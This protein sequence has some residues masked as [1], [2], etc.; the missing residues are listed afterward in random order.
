[1]SPPQQSIARH[2]IDLFSRAV[3]L[4]QAG[5]LDE[6]EPLYT[7]ILSADKRNFDALRLLGLLEAQR[8]NLARAH[9]LLRKALKLRPRSA[10]VFIN[11]GNVLKLQD[12]L[13]EALVAYT[14]ALKIEPNSILAL[15]LR[16]I[17]LSALQRF[18]EARATFDAAL[19]IKHDYAE[20][21]YNRGILLL[22]AHRGAEAL[23]DLDKARALR[24]NDPQILLARGN[25]LLLLSRIDEA[26]ESFERALTIQPG[27]VEAMV[28]LGTALRM[29][30]RLSEALAIYDQALAARADYAEVFFNR[31]LVL[32]D[33]KRFDEALTCL[34]R[35]L[36]LRPDFA[37]A[38]LNRGHTLC[39]LKRFE[40]AAAA[41][42]RA[43]SLKPDLVEVW[44]GRG[45]LF[46]QLKQW[47][48]ALAAYERAAA[49]KPDLAEAYCGSGV[50]FTKTAQYEQA[51]AAY[52]SAIQL[53]P[54]LSEAWLGRG[55]VFYE[56]KRLNEALAAYDKALALNPDLPAAW[57]GRG[58]VFYELKRYT[59][60]IAAYDKAIALQP[61]L[62]EA[63]VRLYAKLMI[64][65][66]A[67]W[68]AEFSRFLSAT[69]NG[70]STHPFQLLSIP[71]SAAD[72][73]ACAKCF[74]A[75]RPLPS[76]APLWRGEV[77]SHDRIRVAYLSSDLR[78]HA[79]GY[80]TAGLFQQHDR[81]RFEL[82]AISFGPE[83]DSDIRHRIKNAFE[84]FID[85]RS[86]TDRQI[87]E[88][89]RQREIDIA[90][91]LNGFTQSDRTNAFASRAAPIQVNYLGFPAT[92][93]ADYIDYIIADQ[94]VIPEWQRQHYQEK[95]I[96]MP[97]C[98]MVNDAKRSISLHV[99][100][101]AEEGLPEE[102]FVFCC[103][104][105]SHKLLPATFDIWMRLLARVDASVLWLSALNESAT[106]NLRVEAQARGIDPS[107]LIFA[108]WV[109]SAAGHLARHRLADLFLDTLPYNAHT[110]ASDALWAGVPVLTCCGETFAGRVAAS[111]LQAVGLPEMVTHSL[112]EY[113]ALALKLA[114]DPALFKSVRLKLEQNRS[115]YPLFN[116]GR[117]TRHL[118]VAYQLMWETW[119]RGERPHSFRVAPLSLK[120]LPETAAELRA[121][122]QRLPA[123]WG[124]F[125]A[126]GE[127]AGR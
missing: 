9:E 15:N 52:D 85:A 21:L 61:D 22:K 92:M 37:E 74:V 100:T 104:N 60:A 105:Q 17:V 127:G 78:E 65:D 116:T 75:D 83:K 99:P 25:A 18:D 38:A 41:Y 82:T 97:D 77:Y 33:L 46:A 122:A 119:Q 49:I 87:A 81:S 103:F 89:V 107:R 113:E 62:V 31:G 112:N 10:E 79:V 66:W 7:R 57:S 86:Y 95:V 102:A 44:L 6:A 47:S 93:G 101:R 94:F 71:S 27:F 59:E 115:C 123:Y 120:R 20:A 90:V 19:K 72:Q 30:N 98:Y 11:L 12:Q 29:Q 32:H 124:P 114:T 40:D 36:A 35:A 3:G 24:P 5:R 56:F 111:L 58:L 63:W 48:N 39:E 117:F 2:T 16:G 108:R 121:G 13:E 69:R 64:C 68:E 23:T 110:T 125:V 34:D 88:L 70:A 118:E 84:H 51:L 28:S 67:D 80:L 50:A 43:L 91:N 14:N 1:M 73:L 106:R 4:H 8:G 53:K 109:A 26:I 45:N 54:E 55:N 126:V 42:D 76:Y 96:Y